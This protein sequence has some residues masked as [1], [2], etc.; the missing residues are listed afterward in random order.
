MCF[1]ND[2]IWVSF[3]FTKTDFPAVF[4]SVCPRPSPA[5]LGSAPGPHQ[6]GIKDAP[7][8]NLCWRT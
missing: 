2:R 4:I 8:V 7:V 1:L 6:A 3:S 5:G